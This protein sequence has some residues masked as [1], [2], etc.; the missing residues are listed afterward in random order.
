MEKSLDLD[1]LKRR[2]QIKMN[3]E[4]NRTS[5]DFQSSYIVHGER[6]S[7]Q[8]LKS[9]VLAKTMVCTDVSL[10]NRPCNSCKSCLA[11]AGL[12]H[13]DVYFLDYED[14]SFIGVDEIR[15]RINDTVYIKPFM[16][17]RKV[18]V[19]FEAEKLTVQA[20]NS[21]LKILEEPPMYA[22]FILSTGNIEKLIP[23]I[24]SRCVKLATNDI[25][26]DELRSYLT[27]VLKLK[28]EEAKLIVAFSF[29]KIE[30]ALSLLEKGNVRVIYERIAILVK[31]FAEGFFD[32]L[33]LE[34]ERLN[35][36]GINMQE[37]LDLLKL[38]FR[39]VMLFK[40]LKDSENL[41]FIDKLSEIKDWANKCSY[42]GIEKILESIDTTQE[43][44][45]ARV[46]IDMA[47][48]LLR[49]QIRIEKSL[50]V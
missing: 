22:H 39:D 14:S 26:E 47:I 12:N 29:G 27:D 6:Y 5:D 19:I 36:E 24:Q 33:M 32:Y 1:E 4:K 15:K 31:R 35:D 25:S 16:S 7:G 8:R 2:V 41:V 13:P 11:V 34:F 45:N 10:N 37:A 50:D 44:I 23:T 17:K 42:E 9:I 49:Q 48:E 18:Y 30:R 20:Q 38:W 21:L 40:A 43:R 46:T 28:E 3:I